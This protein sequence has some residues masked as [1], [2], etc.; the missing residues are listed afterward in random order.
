MSLT[1]GQEVAFRV[2]IYDGRGV[3]EELLGNVA[4]IRQPDETPAYPLAIECTP[5]AEAPDFVEREV[6]EAR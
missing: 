6:A 2:G 3:V 4:K 1:I 5:I